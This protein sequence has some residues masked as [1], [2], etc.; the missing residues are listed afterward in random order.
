MIRCAEDAP[1]RR[2]SRRESVRSSRWD[3]IAEQ[4]GEL[5]GVPAEHS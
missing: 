5:L 2:V 4:H 3:S 1:A